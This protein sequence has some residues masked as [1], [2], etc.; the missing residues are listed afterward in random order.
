MSTEQ[1][2]ASSSSDPMTI[3]KTHAPS[4]G[5]AHQPQPVRI[6]AVQLAEDLFQNLHITPAKVADPDIHLRSKTAFHLF[7]YLLSELAEA[8]TQL[9]EK[10]V[11]LAGHGGREALAKL[12]DNFKGYNRIERVKKNDDFRP[13]DGLLKMRAF[14]QDA[15]RKDLALV[16]SFFKNIAPPSKAVLPRMQL[17]K[18]LSAAPFSS[19]GFFDLGCCGGP[20]AANAIR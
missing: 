19:Q 3:N 5:I 18:C 6:N 17:I 7:S 1:A 2:Q 15:T 12:F 9:V 14:A 8:M 16:E 20:I 4:A 13:P 10:E 11:A